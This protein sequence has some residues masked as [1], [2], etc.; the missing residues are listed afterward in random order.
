M[1]RLLS[2]GGRAL[3]AVNRAKEITQTAREEDSLNILL[4]FVPSG[5]KSSLLGKFGSFPESVANILVDDKGYIKLADFGASKKVAH[6]CSAD[7]WSVGCTVIESAGKPPWRQQYQE[8]AALF[9]IG[10]TKAHPPIPEHLFVEE[11][12]F[13]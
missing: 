1:T 4:E 11:R 13:F 3:I 12:I 8:V 6:W 5:S 7:I 9:H 10:T 2:C